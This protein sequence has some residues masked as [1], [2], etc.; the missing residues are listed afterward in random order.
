[1][2]VTDHATARALWEAGFFGKGILSRSEPNWLESEKTRVGLQ[3]RQTAE[4]FTGS[5]R[6]DREEF[7]RER[8]RIEKELVAEVREREKMGLKGL[9]GG[10]AAD[11][12]PVS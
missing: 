5:R 9:P 10:E 7:K 6:K 11:Q 4:Q 8:A 1:V 12:I 3:G 2:H